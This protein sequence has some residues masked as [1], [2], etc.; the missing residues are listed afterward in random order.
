[1]AAITQ[2]SM[3]AEGT[4]GATASAGALGASAVTGSGTA[5]FSG[6]APKQGS[7]DVLVAATAT[8]E[9]LRWDLSTP[10]TTLWDVVYVKTP[11]SAPAASTTIA[12]WFASDLITT[13]GAVRLNTDM[14]VTL[15]DAST[16]VWTSPSALPTNAWV[17]LA[18]KAIPGS[19]TGHRLRVYTSLAGDA[20]TPDM[21]SG[22]QTCTNAAAADVGQLRLGVVSS[23]TLSL[24][25]DRQR[26]DNATE[27]AGITTGLPP[28]VN[29]GPDLTKET[30]SGTFTITGVPTPSSGTTI[31][32]RSWAIL[33]GVTVALSGTTTDTVTVTAPASTTGST[34]LRYIAVAS[35]G[36]SSPP[37]DVTLTWVAPGQTLYPAADVSNA[38][39]WTTQSGGTSSLFASVDE[40][41]LDTSDYIATPQ[42]SASAAG[43]KFRLGAKPAPTNTTG[44]YLRLNV[45]VTA[46]VA[47]S[48]LVAKLYESDGTTLRK[49]WSAIT[50]ANTT[51]TEF[52]LT[53][54]A[55]EVA[56][57]TSW[58]SGLII[59]LSATGS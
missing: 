27:P 54:T 1:M 57:I 43:V 41:V 31:A 5:T 53:L 52:Q 50:S 28:T 15:R 29:A 32:S 21:D 46:D 40:P 13:V 10:V 18:I 59:E 48:S 42:L 3:D 30:G 38:G 56:A 49:T 17:R 8:T 58:A 6:T 25:F 9:I 44:W 39:S 22:N 19:S 24:H 14:T 23:S 47:A 11:S 12:S 16:G 55:G 20:V 33:S 37:D 26:A 4:D 35:D 36:Q 2:L 51:D 7:T 34:V 45:R